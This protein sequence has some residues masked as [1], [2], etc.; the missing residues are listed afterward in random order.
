MPVDYQGVYML[1]SGMLSQ[2]RKLEVITNNLAVVMLQGPIR[3]TGNPLDL[4]IEGKGFFA[5]RSGR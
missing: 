4:A 5:V 3:E 2:E 1:S